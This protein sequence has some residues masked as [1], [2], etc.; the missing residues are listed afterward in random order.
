M[1][2]DRCSLT[3]KTCFLLGGAEMLGR[4]GGGGCRC[5]SFAGFPSPALGQ[6]KKPAAKSD[7][8]RRQSP[9][10]KISNFGPATACNWC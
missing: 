6:E 2:F 9:S 3:G 4:V 1:Q 8:E 5:V 10:P 7:K